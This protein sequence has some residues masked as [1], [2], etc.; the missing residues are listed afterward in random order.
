MLCGPEQF[1]KGAKSILPWGDDPDSPPRK[2]ESVTT[3]C[4][5]PKKKPWTGALHMS[6]CLRFWSFLHIRTWLRVGNLVQRVL[7]SLFMCYDR[8]QAWG[9]FFNIAR[10]GLM[11]FA[12]STCV[13]KIILLYQTCFNDYF[14]GCR[15]SSTLTLCAILV[16]D[17]HQHQ[18]TIVGEH[19]AGSGGQYSPK[20]WW[21]STGNL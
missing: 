19:N 7:E 2:V 5:D 15:I 16:N 14:Y 4:L 18:P 6:L 11:P 1:F 20:T 9:R 8:H 3:R 13:W 12:A 21:T 17:E 10:T